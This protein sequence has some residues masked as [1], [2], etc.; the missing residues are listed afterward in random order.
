MDKASQTPSRRGAP[1]A[2]RRLLD[3]DLL[4]VFVTVVDHGGFTAAGTVLHRSQAAISLQIKRLEDSTR[5]V[6]LHQPRQ[7]LRLTEDGE[8]L[9]DYARRM[10][11]LNDEALASLSSE[12][13]SGKIRIAS[14][15]DYSTNVLPELLAEFCSLYPKVQIEQQT[16]IVS[17]L[18]R[19]LGSAF[20]LVVGIQ[21]SG[22]NPPGLLR[23]ERVRW[24]TS[25][26]R[27]PHL[28]EPLP[29]AFLP[30]GTLFRDWAIKALAASGRDWRLAHE[31]ANATATEAAVAAGLAVTVFKESTVTSPSLKTLGEADG[32]P[33]LPLVDVVL[34]SAPSLSRSALR[35]HD[36]LL[37]RLATT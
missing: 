4:R 32:F 12:Q 8:V 7:P 5:T 35:L 9:L 13:I 10:I 34:F 1:G 22:A 25:A 18:V 2:A 31:S 24:V 17:E 21:E 30:A 15:M 37:K 33:P 28:Q 36:F 3:N 27:S 29:M 14:I 16:G 23:T 6:L 26:T 20:D 19:K 11:A